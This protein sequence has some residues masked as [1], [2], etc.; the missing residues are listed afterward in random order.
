MP[1]PPPFP[2]LKCVQRTLDQLVSQQKLVEK[3]YGKQKVYM[4]NQAQFPDFPPEELKE[5]ERK[6]AELQERLKTE[7][8]ECRAME[9]RM[10]V[11]CIGGTH[12]RIYYI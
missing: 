3:V 7:M 10:Q 5:M 2:S 12:V 4:A 6:I 8:G 9:S 1:L 11:E